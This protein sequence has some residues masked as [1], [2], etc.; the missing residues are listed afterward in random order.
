LETLYNNEGF[1]Y[2]NEAQKLEVKLLEEKKRTYYWKKRKNGGS[3]VEPYGFKQGDENTKFFHRYVNK[4]KN[5]NSVWKIDK[6]ND[7]GQQILRTLLK[8][9]STTSQ[10][11]LGRTLELLL[12]R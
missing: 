7:I 1:G 11:F 12:L 10:T 6:G 4:R 3:R 8:K 5:I 9:E 2:L